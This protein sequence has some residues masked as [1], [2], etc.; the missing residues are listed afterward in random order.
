MEGRRGRYDAFQDLGYSVGASR[1]GRA[2]PISERETFA[3][4]TLALAVC[5]GVALLANLLAITF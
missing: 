5:L 1:I 4:L 2:E 3:E